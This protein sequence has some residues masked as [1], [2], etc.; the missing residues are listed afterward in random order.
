MEDNSPDN[1]AIEV[2]DEGEGEEE[3]AANQVEEVTLPHPVLSQEV[4]RAGIQETL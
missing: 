3:V 1:V 4:E 2:A